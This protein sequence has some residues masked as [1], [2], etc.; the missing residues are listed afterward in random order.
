MKMYQMRPDIW[1]NLDAITL[2]IDRGYAAAKHQIRIYTI[3]GRHEYELSNEE[4]ARL[5]K[6]VEE[7]K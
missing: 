5:Q 4:W 2:V 3:D 1:I 7:H 6:K